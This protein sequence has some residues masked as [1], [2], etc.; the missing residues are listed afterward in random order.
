METDKIVMI[1]CL[2]ILII[3]LLHMFYRR[4]KPSMSVSVT[5]KSVS[6]TPMFRRPTAGA[7]KYYPAA[8]PYKAQYY[9]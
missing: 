9:N 8:N 7:P 3:A 2:L 4:K 5:K 1:V 6:S